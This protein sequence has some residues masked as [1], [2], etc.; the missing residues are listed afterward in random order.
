MESNSNIFCQ[1][2]G[3]HL[4]E[5]MEEKKKS[6]YAC[7]GEMMEILSSLLGLLISYAAWMLDPEAFSWTSPLIP[8]QGKSKCI[9]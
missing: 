6:I 9:C 5:I 7:A 2:R 8:S 1:A 4:L 3:H